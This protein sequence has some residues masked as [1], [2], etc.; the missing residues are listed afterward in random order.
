M[1]SIRFVAF[2]NKEE[3]FATMRNAVF[4]IFNR[5]Y[6]TKDTRAVVSSGKTHPVESHSIEFG[7]RNEFRGRLHYTFTLVPEQE[8]KESFDDDAVVLFCSTSFCCVPAPV[9]LFSYL[10]SF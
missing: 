3:T 4:S 1:K 10:Q 2:D 5:I 9:T 6:A 7:S 8:E